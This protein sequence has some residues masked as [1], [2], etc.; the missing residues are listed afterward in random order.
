M[1]IL[2]NICTA[3][4][5]CSSLLLIGCGG[6]GGTSDTSSSEISSWSIYDHLEVTA[7][8]VAVNVEPIVSYDFDNPDEKKNEIKDTSGK[9]NYDATYTTY[10]TGTGYGT[11]PSGGYRDGGLLFS[12]RGTLVVD[13]TAGK[14]D[15]SIHEQLSGNDL[16]VSLWFN[17]TNIQYTGNIRLISKKDA[18]DAATGFDVEISREHKR[19][20]VLTQ[21]GEYFQALNV[22]IDFEWHHLSVRI[23]GNSGDIF[24]DGVN[25]TDGGTASLA[26]SGIL[27][28]AIPLTIGSHS[29]GAVPFQGTLDNVRIYNQFVTD[30]SIASLYSDEGL[31]RNLLAHWDFESIDGKGVTP[32]LTVNDHDAQTHNI[33]TETGP[34]GLGQ[35]ITFDG[36]SSW[37]DCGGEESL[38]LSGQMTISAWVKVGDNTFDR[39]MRILSKKKEY[40]TDNGFEFEYNPFIQR[41]SFTGSGNKVARANGVDLG[42]NEWHMVTAVQSGTRVQFYID[43]VAVTSYHDEAGAVITDQLNAHVSHGE[44]NAITQ[45]KE[46]VCLGSISAKNQNGI[47]AV[48]SGAMDD[49]RIYDYPLTADEIAALIPAQTVNQ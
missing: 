46:A 28:N 10:D 39:Y 27:E 17:H 34:T 11:I 15:P 9:P 40:E 47:G 19:I 36:T 14:N 5:L 35:A 4:A 3:T 30:S 43:G 38:A 7:L 18:W 6:G 13:E 22:P 41:L 20:R 32:D 26:S 31:G 25:V 45:K 29:S 23:N 16:C 44:I 49:V 37:V 1:A 33:V 48:W 42:L 21:G 8:K 2:Q 12:E 24:L